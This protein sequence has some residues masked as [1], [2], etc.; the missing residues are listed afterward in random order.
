MEAF[1]VITAI[2]SKLEPKEF[3][4]AVSKEYDTGMYYTY[5]KD[6]MYVTTARQMM[7]LLFKKQ[8]HIQIWCK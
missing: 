1:S 5:G 8:W 3:T 6:L 7:F 2:M 4:Q